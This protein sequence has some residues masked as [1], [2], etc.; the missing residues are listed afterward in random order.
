MHIIHLMKVQL[1]YWKW[2]PI[3]NNDVDPAAK[4]PKTKVEDARV[5]EGVVP[6]EVLVVRHNAIEYLLVKGERRDCCQ[7]PAVAYIEWETS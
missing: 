7:Q 3:I 5:H 6:D 2:I 4:S 1:P